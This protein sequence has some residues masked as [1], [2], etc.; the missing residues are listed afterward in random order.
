[1]PFTGPPPMTSRNDRNLTTTPIAAYDRRNQRCIT[2][3]AAYFADETE[4]ARWRAAS[5]WPA[6]VQVWDLDRS[7]G[8][9]RLRPGHQLTLAPD[10]RY[11]HLFNPQCQCGWKAAGF[12]RRMVA[13]LLYDRH[14]PTS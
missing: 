2:A 1:M 7:T 3:G 5:N 11:D 10:D 12:T 4:L 6:D 8:E 14:L 13:E 9:W